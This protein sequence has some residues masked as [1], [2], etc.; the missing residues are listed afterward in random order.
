MSEPR[1][2]MSK[3][4]LR[5]VVV[6]GMGT[7]NPLG[8]TLKA[9]WDGLI[10]GKSGIGRITHFDVSDMPCQIGGEVK[11]FDPLEY[12]DRKDAR[13]SPRVTQMILAATSQAV[14][15]AGLPYKMADPER[16]GVMVGTGVGGL[17]RIMEAYNVLKNDGFTRLNPFHLPSAIPNM[18]ASQIAIDR[19]CYGPN[20]TVTTACAAGTQ[21]VGTGAEWIREGLADII[22]SGGTEAVVMELVLGAFSVMRAL[23]VNYNE[24]PTEASRPFDSKRE[25]FVLSEGAAVLILESLEHA[26]ARGARIYA[27][28][29]GHA[30]SSDAF[31]VAAMEPE[32]AGPG[33]AMKWAL[34]D[35]NVAPDQI[36]Y[37][38]AHGTS[39]PL[40][41]LTETKAIKT[42]FGEAAY[43][44]PISST[45][46]MVGHAMGASGAMEAI[47]CSMAIHEETIPPTIN[48]ETPDPECDL[49]YVPNKSMKKKIRYA[50]SNSFGLGGQNACLV[51]GRYDADEKGEEK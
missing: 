18:P 15:D 32:G 17:D 28:V 16:A 45:K 5:R 43:D 7:I 49:N 26:L 24:R 6:T 51:L 47:A 35:A 31:H 2:E 21:A 36:D 30:S 22:I 39:T 42:V 20:S 9:Y 14:S 8:N 40:N 4:P 41:D 12:M 33:R 29:M 37:I 27:E 25:G 48:Y 34:K 23:P 1:G 10:A 11:N 44:I 3:N 50:L 46:S 19:Q 13:R 38:N